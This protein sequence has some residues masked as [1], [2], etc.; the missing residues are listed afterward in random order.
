MN[1]AIAKSRPMNLV[2]RNPL[3]A[4]KNPPQDLSNPVN[5]KNVEKDQGGDPASGN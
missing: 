3:S 2:L 5:Q 4:R 1:S